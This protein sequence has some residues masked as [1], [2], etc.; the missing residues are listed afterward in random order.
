MVNYA[1]GD[2]A[3]RERVVRFIHEYFNALHGEVAKN[4]LR[5]DGYFKLFEKL[6][7]GSL[8]YYELYTMFISTDLITW[9]IDFIMEKQ[10]PINIIQKKYSLGTKSNPVAFGSGL[11]IIL[12]LLK[13]VII[14][15][16][17]LSGLLA[18]TMRSLSYR[19]MSSSISLITQSAVSVPWLSTKR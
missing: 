7:E 13:R 9:F 11:N 6:L 3:V 12:F 14:T 16:Y 18:I 2:V 19:P 17:S 10:S 1:S 8:A 5:I 15:L 4:W